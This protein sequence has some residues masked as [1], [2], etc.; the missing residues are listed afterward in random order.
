MRWIRTGEIRN[1]DAILIVKSEERG[2]LRDE[3]IRQCFLKIGCAV[4]DWNNQTQKTVVG[5][6][7]CGYQKGGEFLDQLND[8]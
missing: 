7:E 3:K 8:C 5:S 4:V 1:A 6:C 2:K